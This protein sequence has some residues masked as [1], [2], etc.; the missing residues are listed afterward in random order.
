[1]YLHS[2]SFI[3]S[4]K[5]FKKEDVIW[6]V[7]ADPIHIGHV[8]KNLMKEVV[9]PVALTDTETEIKDD[10]RGNNR[11]IQPLKGR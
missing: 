10:G 6:Y 3:K 4:N 9:Y 8:T 5:Y 2:C 1:M 11:V 7:T